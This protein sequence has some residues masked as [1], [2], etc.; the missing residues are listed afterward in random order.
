MDC[1]IELEQIIGTALSLEEDYP[2]FSL[3]KMDKANVNTI[4]GS[5]DLLP[6]AQVQVPLQNTWQQTLLELYSVLG[7]PQE[8]KVGRTMHK[9]VRDDQSTSALSPGIKD[10]PSERSSCLKRPLWEEEERVCKKMKSE[11]EDLL[12]TL[13]AR[14]RKRTIYTKEQ[15]DFL[16]NQFDINPYPDFVSRCHIAQLTGVP[17][18][19]IQVWFQNRRAR[20]LS[21]IHRSQE[22]TIQEASTL[23]G[24]Q[25]LISHVHQSTNPRSPRSQDQYLPDMVTCMVTEL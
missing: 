22:P 16:Q 24:T 14:S 9:I 20:H 19:R 15:T 3:P 5:I 23:T 18:P 17:E 21:K 12:P 4:R 2:E 10:K 25:K 7:I 6:A 11:P 1:D 13:S 8:V